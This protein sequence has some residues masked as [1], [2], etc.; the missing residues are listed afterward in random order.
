MLL[1]E[2]IQTAFEK[3]YKRGDKH[4]LLWALNEVFF[5]E[6]WFAGACRM[7]ADVLM[8][9]NPFILRYLIAFA[10][11][12]Y[13]AQQTGEPG[14]SVGKGVGLAVG[15]ALIQG[16]VSLCAGQFVFHSMMVGGQIRAGL[17]AMIFD[18]SLKISARARAGGM[19]KEKGEEKP[20]NKKGKKGTK[21]APKKEGEGSAWSNGRVVNLMGTDTYRID[22][23]RTGLLG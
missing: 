8:V 4:P 12:S 19:I 9:I 17:I 23:V 18:K 22:Q 13:R 7:T 16:I 11:E 3:R 21:D 6:Y 20:E 14:P 15:I 10:V 2:R 1:T 5:W